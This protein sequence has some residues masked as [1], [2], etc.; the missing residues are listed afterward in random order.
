MEKCSDLS[1][2]MLVILSW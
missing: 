2:L 1:Q